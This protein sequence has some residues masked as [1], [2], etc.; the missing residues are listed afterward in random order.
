M[1]SSS[2]EIRGECDAGH[3][4]S[5]AWNHLVHGSRSGQFRRAGQSSPAQ[6][7]SGTAETNEK[8]SGTSATD[9]LTEN[10]PGTAERPRGS[11]PRSVP[12]RIAEDAAGGAVP[13][14]KATPQP[15]VTPVLSMVRAVPPGPPQKN[16]TGEKF[17]L[18]Y[19]G[20][21]K[22]EMLR[23]L[24]PPSSRVVVPDDD[25]HLPESLQRWVKGSPM[26]TVRLDSGRVVQIE[27]RP[28]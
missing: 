24:G 11:S 26:G 25:G 23:V 16:L 5:S 17:A 9:A 21:T 13:A 12:T 6:P 15:I 22:K 7:T 14:A 3:V 27:T 8:H 20:S 10:A 19:I 4:N 2:H 1:F 28:K 18:I